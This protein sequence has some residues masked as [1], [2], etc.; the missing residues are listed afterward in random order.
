M[1]ALILIVGRAKSELFQNSFHAFG[2]LNLLL[3]EQPEPSDQQ[4]AHFTC[5]FHGPRCE[6]EWLSL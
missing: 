5:S 2:D 6:Q 3:M 1:P 4:Q